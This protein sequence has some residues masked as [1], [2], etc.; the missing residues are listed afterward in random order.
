[1]NEQ[2]LR[3]VRIAMVVL[4]LAMLV[5][6]QQSGV[7][8]QLGDPAKARAALLAMGPWG[9]LAFVLAYALLQP[10]G[11]PGT[12]FI[13]V[14]PLIWSWPIAFALSMVGTMAASVIGFAFARFV[15]RDW[16]IKK[17]PP[18]ISRY[19]EALEKR[20]F[21]T[22]LL[23]RLLFW[24]P[25]WLHAFFGVSKVPFSTHFWASLLGYTP[26]LLLTAYFGQ[27]FFDW[28]RTAPP[29]VWAAVFVPM[30]VIGATVWWVQKRRAKSLSATT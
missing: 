1:M 6:A 23:L 20:A 21:S 11:V 8:A 18:R 24:M 13:V 16:V 30:L 3:R 7:L 14:A 12:V 9:Y 17:I 2:W 15:A 26:S 19:N 27:R 28:M 25:P 22:V 29:W 4:V 10:F 5:G